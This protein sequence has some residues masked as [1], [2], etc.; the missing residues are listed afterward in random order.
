MVNGERVL[1]FKAYCFDPV[2]DTAIGEPGRAMEQFFCDV[3][4]AKI[5]V[6][7]SV[8]IVNCVADVP[9]TRA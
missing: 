4:W 6:I 1:P 8:F 3:A 2:E 5:L 9:P 7:T